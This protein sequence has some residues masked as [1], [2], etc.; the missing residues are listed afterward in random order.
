M[1]EFI[2]TFETLPTN[3]END[4]LVRIDQFEDKI[5]EIDKLTKQYDALKKEIKGQM[6]TIG[7]EHGLTQVKWITPNGTQITCSIGQLE[8]TKEITEKRFNADI[9]KEKYPDIYNECCVDRTYLSVIKAKGNDT[10]RITLP[11]GD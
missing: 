1:E 10:L 7:K 8:E 3:K 6:V 9:L 4:I 11:K 5:R 2:P